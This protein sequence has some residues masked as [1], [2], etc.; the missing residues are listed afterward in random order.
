[1]KSTRS[2]KSV[3]ILLLAVLAAALSASLASAQ[4]YEGK[5]TLPF[6]ARWGMAVLPPGDYTFH[7]TACNNDG[8]WNEEGTSIAV[9]VTPPFWKTWWFRTFGFIAIL[10]SVGGSIRYVEMKKLKRT[11]LNPH[12]QKTTLC[13]ERY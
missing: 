13:S 3:R 8:V 6:E 12:L 5:F 1:M 11:S 10:L 9:I 4:D 2:L 7:V